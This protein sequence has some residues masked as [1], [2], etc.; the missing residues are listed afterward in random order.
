MKFAAIVLAVVTSVAGE[1]QPVAER[2]ATDAAVIDR[3]A[4]ASVRDLPAGLL[5]RIV[6]ED[7]ELMRGR[8]ADGSYENARWERFEAGRVTESFS[9]RSGG[10]TMETLELKGALVYRAMLEVPERRLVVRKNV[11]VWI[12]RLEV[13]FV[14]EANRPE[15]TT[16]DIKSWLQPGEYRPVDL[17]AVA[18]Q[19]TVRVVATA[20]PGGRYGNL[21]VSLIQ[22]RIVDNADSPWAAAVAGA[23]AALKA[24]EAND[25]EALSQAA[26]KMAEGS[27]AR[28]AASGSESS[29][30]AGAADLRA[31]LQAVE[32]LL[33][34][35]EEERRTG[36][37]R[38][39]QLIRRLREE[40]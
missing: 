22:A 32:D 29:G 17:P 6:T 9:V 31:E 10:D 37:D 11:P 13:D 3:V 15:R 12:E 7:I 40:R 2:I 19:A 33:T 39:H 23:K 5:E 21:V 18:K 34:G 28:R 35:S 8:R 30:T 16:I 26:R 38:L 25:V 14:A 24:L 36:M 1:K 20:D 4:Q 27:G